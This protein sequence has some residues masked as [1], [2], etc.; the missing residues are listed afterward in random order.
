MATPT[1]AKTA[2]KTEEPQQELTGLRARMHLMHNPGMYAG[3]GLGIASGYLT[4]DP[5]LLTT[6]GATGAAVGWATL[7]MNPGPWRW[8]PG[9]GEPWEWM[10]RS[11]RRGYRRSLRRMRRRLDVEQY[12][13]LPGWY[14]HPDRPALVRAATAEVRR[15]RCEALRTAW[16]RALP[17][18]ESGWWR[19]YTP[20]E[21]ALRAGPLAVIP[22]SG[23]AEM[24]WWAHLTVISIGAGW[25]SRVW[26]R[27]A[28]AGTDTAG[29]KGA[30]W[31]VARWAEWI[32]CERGPL[33][34]SKLASVHLDGD[35]LTAIVISTTAK[36]ALSVDQDSI[37]IAFRVPPRAVNVYRPDD[38]A[39][40]RAKLTVR[41]RA[42]ATDL[43]MDD[44]AAV[45]EEFNPYPGS[46][47]CDAQKTEHGRSFKLLMPRKGAS[48]ADV[49]PR[50]IAQALDLE[51]EEAVA[52]LHLRM[53][54][55]RRIEVSEMTRNPLQAGV[56][57]DLDAL[58]MD[59]EGYIIVGKDVHGRPTKWRL[60]KFD[61]TRRGLSGRPSASA[62]HAFGSGT[63][64]A[65]K[66]S[67]E[68]DLQVAQRKNG[69]VSWLADG[70]GGAG[71]APWM[72]ELDWL[73]KSPYGAMLMGQAANS[74]SEYRYA[75]QMK[76]QWLD[77]DG[78][79]EQ[80]RSFFVPGEPFAPM[81]TTWD[82]FNEMILKDP[83]ADHV[84][85]L[86]RSVSSVGRLSRAAGIAARIWVQIPNL[87]SIGSDASAN[88]IRDMLQSGNI[89][90]FR[91]ARADVDIMSLGSR[92]PEIR[93]APLPERFPNGSETGG[94]CYI[95]DGKAQY[96]QSRAM[97]HTNPARVA[98]EF[99]LQTLTRQEADAAAAAGPAGLAYLRRE[100]YRHLDAGEEEE[101]LRE[102][103]A[104]EQEKS[105]KNVK[106][107][108]SRPAPVAPAAV[109]VEDDD[110]DELVPPTRSQLVW[111]AVDGGAR[112][113]RQI[114]EVTDLTRTNVA[115]ATARLERLG[116]LAKKQQDWHTAEPLDTEPISA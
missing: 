93:L 81:V 88:A 80:G 84:K 57:L 92:T 115:N 53:L 102:L 83:H 109:E 4:G 24:P 76:M 37:S 55:A 105:K 45:W 26:H 6:I 27:P 79:T 107:I 89:A 66:T 77:A 104:K 56:P 22:A 36:P 14:A 28:P 116:K 30:D 49:Q 59:D 48:V 33:P 103:V 114:A 108:G 32:A 51:G 97:F 38:M 63:T 74:V 98:R 91:T 18:W 73:L 69:F 61:A 17:N 39:A 113:N 1:L 15:K 60:L 41:L 95:A 8:L 70:K 19:R 47:L 29:P 67:L 111:H 72:P 3:A 58:T 87:D 52:R 100:E 68:E 13:P 82:E 7:G 35:K 25:G 86:L 94:L 23:F 110:L 54:D 62:V 64:G 46:K 85:P 101:F 2:T 65:G 78:Y 20:A 43:D 99:P 96:T 12:E 90:L 50:A 16:T 31:Y 44:L 21:M 42:S 71:Y 40:D 112:R 9:Q 106:V 11:S 5:L 34:A 10:C 75:E